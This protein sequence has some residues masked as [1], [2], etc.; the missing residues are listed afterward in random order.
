ML[1]WY[2]FWHARESATLILSLSLTIVRQTARKKFGEGRNAEGGFW[3]AKF[4]QA[5]LQTE[6]N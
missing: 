4:M 6:E 2:G 1:E 3:R 5:E